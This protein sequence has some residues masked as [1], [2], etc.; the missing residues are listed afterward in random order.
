MELLSSSLFDMDI[1]ELLKRLAIAESYNNINND[2]FIKNRKKIEVIYSH[3]QGLKSLTKSF[4]NS[5]IFKN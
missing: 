4:G 5:H 2:N 1:L 3:K